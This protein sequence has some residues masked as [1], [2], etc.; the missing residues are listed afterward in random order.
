MV[1]EHTLRL[2]VADVDGD[3][4]ALGAAVTTRLCGH[5]E[6][7]GPC[8]WPHHNDAVA[9]GTGAELTVHYDAAPDDVAAVADEIVAGLAVGV[10]TG[11]DGDTTTWGSVRVADSR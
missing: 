8:R 4:R 1:F 6:H 3:L 5:W 7:D 2:Q 10:L 11:P 9:D